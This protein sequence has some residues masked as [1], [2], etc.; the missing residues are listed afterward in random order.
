MTKK[1]QLILLIKEC[2]REILKENDMGDRMITGI[3]YLTTGVPGGGVS[4]FSSPSVSQN[5]V[6]FYPVGQNKVDFYNNYSAVTPDKED[7][8]AIKYKVTPDE[9]LQGLEYERKKMFHKDP[10]KAKAIVV[11]NLKKNPKY[12]SSLSMLINSD[13]QP[14]PEI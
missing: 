12:Y 8:D 1:R 4:T 11:A 3:S 7:I 13:E 9:I 10:S 6:N 5:P 14:S 2:L